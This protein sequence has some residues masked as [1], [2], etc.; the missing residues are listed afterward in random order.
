MSAQQRLAST[1]DRFTRV[2]ARWIAATLVSFLLLASCAPAQQSGKPW[3]QRLEER[4]CIEACQTTKAA[5]ETAARFDYRQCQADYSQAFR[6]YR[7]CL[8]AAA[9]RGDCGYPWWPCAE[10]SFGACANRAS[11]CERACRATPAPAETPPAPAQSAAA[12]APM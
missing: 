2:S 9:N 8:A 7:W 12:R 11:A 1:A 10:N 3:S 5:C 6:D 4:Q